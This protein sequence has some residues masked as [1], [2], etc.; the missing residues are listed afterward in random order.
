MTAGQYRALSAPFRGGRREKALL[1]VN[2]ALTGLCYAAYPVLL[3]ALALGRDGRF[4]PALLVPAVSF[5]LVSLVRRGINAPRPYEALDIQPII[6]KDTQGKSM[7][8]RHVFSIF[9]IAMTFLWV[10]PWAGGVLLGLGALL[11]CIRVVGGVH[12]PRDVIAGAAAGVFC[13]AVGF[14]ALP[15]LF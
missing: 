7:P 13:G 2:R 6:Q 3:I 4:W 5:A 10:L 12:F 15:A 11:G 9:M 14:W 8:S 1:A